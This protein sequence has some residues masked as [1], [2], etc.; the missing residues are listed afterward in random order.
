MSEPITV[1]CPVDHLADVTARVAKAAKR[2]ERLGI[3]KPL[4]SVGPVRVVPDP[5]ADPRLDVRPLIE[6]VDL[7][8]T[9]PAVI[10]LSGWSLLGRVDSLP[11]GSPI[12]ARTPG[13]DETP[14]PVVEAANWCDH[15]RTR[16]VRTETF[17][18]LHEA[19]GKVAQVGRN[20]LRDF[21]G[22]DPAHLLWWN[23]FVESTSD[24][25][26]GL[27]GER[28]IPTAELVRLAARVAAH[29]G[30]LGKSKAR[31]LTEERGMR[32]WSTADRVNDYLF[33]LPDMLR[34]S[35][36][37]REARELMERWER[38]Y[39]DDEATEALFAATFAAL[40]DLGPRPSEWAANVAMVLG[41]DVVRP[42]HFGVAVSS[43]VLGLKRLDAPRREA[44]EPVV[45]VPLGTVGERVT[46][47][48][49]VT[50]VRHFDSD[51]GTRT[52][53]KYRSGE[54]D[55]A[56]W[57]SGYVE[58]EVGEVVRLRGTVKGHEVDRFTKRPVT[59]LSRVAV[60]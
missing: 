37:G 47:E 46:I 56:W 25:I 29:G 55:L 41:Q 36:E 20:C 8:L 50:F 15:C 32:V 22:I 35:R 5:N 18:V 49:A 28:V 10:G 53:V 21:L 42:R 13:T 24:Y 39:P 43:V 14:L 26:G 48:A 1:T 19:D 33:V 31:E 7:T 45:S 2:C 30:F 23:D 9:A 59:Y 6:V 27:R 60:M 51:W 34:S 40:D 11:D 58:P 54:S 44:A 38:D 12:V 4:L 52:L 17:L 57:A 16:R 3:D